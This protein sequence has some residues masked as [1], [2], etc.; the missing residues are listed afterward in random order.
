[1]TGPGTA[2]WV[3]PEV[4]VWIWEATREWTT[5]VWLCDPCAEARQSLPD[6]AAW[7]MTRRRLAPPRNIRVEGNA[8]PADMHDRIRLTCLDCGANT[9]L[10]HG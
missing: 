6:R 3:R 4:Q 8:C 1:M 5:P 10:G 2:P 9:A 7:R